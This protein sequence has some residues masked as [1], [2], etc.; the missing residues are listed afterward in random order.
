MAEVQAVGGPGDGRSSQQCRFPLHASGGDRPEQPK[1]RLGDPSQKGRRSQ[2]NGCHSVTG[3]HHQGSGGTKGER[4][5]ADPDA[6]IILLVTHRVDGVK[7]KGPNHRGQPGEQQGGAPGPKGESFPSAQGDPRD[8]HRKTPAKGQNQLGQGKPAFGGGIKEHQGQAGQRQDYTEASGWD[9]QGK[10]D[11]QRAHEAGHQQAPGGA[12]PDAS[13]GQGTGFGAIHQWIDGPIPEIIGDAARATHGKAAQHNPP[14]QAG[15]RG[16]EGVQPER[17]ASGDQQ[18]Q[19][20]AGLVPAQQFQ[21]GSLH[22][23]HVIGSCAR[24]IAAADGPV[25]TLNGK[26]APPA[27]RMVPMGSNAPSSLPAAGTSPSGE[28]RVAAIDIGTNSI[29]LLIAAVDPGLHSFRVLLAEK[30]TTRLGE[31]DPVTG[32]LGGEAIERAFLT[33]RHCRD[34]AQSHG[35]E[36][37]LTAATSAVRE[38]PNGREVLQAIEDQLGLEV[39]LVSGPEEAR[40]IYLGVLSGMAFGQTPHLILDIGG[41]S[42][43]LILA[44]GSDARVLTS[45]RIGAVRL[46]RD[47]GQDDPMPPSRRGFLEAYIQ[48]ALDPAVAMVKQALQPG[49]KPLMVATSG[50]ALAMAA[51][52]AAEEG[53]PPIRLQGYRLSRSRID[54]LLTRLMT[55]PLEQRRQLPGINERRAEIIVP[56]ALIL[57]TAM[58]MLQMRELVVCERALREGLIV[59]WMLRQGLLD[60]RFAF[61][62]TIRERTVLHLARTYGVD[63]ERA[64]RVSTVALSLYDQTQGWLHHDDGPGRR[65]L[66]AAA[67]L[68]ACGM[69]INVG[70]YHKHSW[71]LIRHGELLGY[72]EAEHLMVAAIARYHRRSLPKKRHESWQLIG[73]REDRRT[74]SSMALLLRMAAALDRRPGAVVASVR[75]QRLNP[76]AFAVTLMPEPSLNGEGWMDL[77]LEAWSLRSCGPLVLE[78]SGMEL[79]VTALA[80]GEPQAGA[81]DPAR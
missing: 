53:R 57:H 21:P 40:L 3:P 58:T 67:Q 74:V 62:S 76:G 78:A 26:V 77:S 47:F 25:G 28:R 6:S 29:H 54:G 42:T 56:G 80:T 15:G 14:H 16:R 68:H 34:L 52:G 72:S 69:H 32:D 64:S 36:Q 48:G 7:A 23:R 18:N 22:G 8:Q 55:L 17:P 50:T 43:E 13:I 59:D 45:T 24:R 11:G 39:D 41:G 5:A 61:Q 31:R 9:R 1:G 79:H 75:A 63:L 60:D 49:E 37:I 2:G 71:Y 51:L 73:G 4:A 66:W 65:L 38:A 30:S 46:Q 70:A 44:D 20:A 35:V 19:S 33:L 12:H 81:G 10:E 27:P